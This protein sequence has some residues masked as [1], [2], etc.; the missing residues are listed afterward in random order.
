MENHII[1]VR[2]HS[3]P[4]PCLIVS[5]WVVIQ[6]ES[7][8]D[9]AFVHADVLIAG[10]RR[11]PHRRLRRID[12]IDP[13]RIIDMIVQP[14]HNPVIICSRGSNIRFCESTFALLYYLILLFLEYNV[15]TP[16]C[17]CAFGLP[18]NHIVRLYPAAFGQPI[19]PHGAEGRRGITCALLNPDGIEAFAG[20]NP[21]HR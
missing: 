9:S 4:A 15:G 8:H 18:Y 14:Q 17:Q 13:L 20:A 21:C 5:L 3:L 10:Q 19:L 11:F 1:P 6:N 12:A 2:Q 7:S 16:L